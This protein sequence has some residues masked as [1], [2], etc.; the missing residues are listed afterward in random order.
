MLLRFSLKRVRLAASHGRAECGL[1]EAFSKLHD[2]IRESSF[3]G[4]RGRQ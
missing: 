4:T 1:R 2:F 3:L